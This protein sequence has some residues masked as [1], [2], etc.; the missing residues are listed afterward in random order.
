MKKALIVGFLLVLAV[1]PLF[2]H[3]HNGSGHNNG[4]YPLCSIQD[5]YVTDYHYHNGIC[6]SGHSFNDGHNW[7]E[8]CPANNCNLA[9][10]HAHNGHHYFS[11]SHR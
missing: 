10:V 11:R 5:C 1:L 8:I 3:G 2:A 7:H 6:Y 9:G 4:Y